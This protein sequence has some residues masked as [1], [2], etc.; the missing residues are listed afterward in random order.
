V[1]L[2]PKLIR[3]TKPNPAKVSTFRLLASMRQEL[4][5]LV[6]ISTVQEPHTPT[7]QPS[8]VPFSFSHH[9]EISIKSGWHRLGLFACAR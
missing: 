6:S 1:T 7:L 4:T 5:G 3:M 2:N 9:V 8:T